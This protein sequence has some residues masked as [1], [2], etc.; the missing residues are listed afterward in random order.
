MRDVEAARLS[1]L[2]LAISTCGRTQN[3]CFTE[4]QQRAIIP[5]VV[6]L[7]TGA[8]CLLVSLVAQLEPSAGG[9]LSVLASRP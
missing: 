1:G 6:E 4:T 2:V 8:G 5:L 3:G 9:M 7:C